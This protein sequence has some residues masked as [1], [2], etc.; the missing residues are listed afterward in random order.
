[1]SLVP[2]WVG[3]EWNMF[4]VKTPLELLRRL[5]EYIME[6]KSY[7]DICDYKPIQ[8]EDENGK[9]SPCCECLVYYPIHIAA[10]HGDI[11]LVKHIELRTKNQNPETGYERNPF[12]LAAFQGHLEICKWYITN[13]PNTHSAIEVN[14]ADYNGWTVLH[15]AASNDQ[16]E[17]F[18]YLLEHGADLY[19]KDQEG[20][21]ALHIAAQLN[22]L[23]ICKLIVEIYNKGGVLVNSSAN[24]RWGDGETPLHTATRYGHTEIVEFILA[25]VVDKNPVNENGDTPLSLAA[26]Y[27]FMEIYRI[28]C[29]HVKDPVPLELGTLRS[30]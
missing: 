16:V 29:Q 9:W 28:I 15:L 19:L 13:I 22:S 2:K 18:N 1:M 21:T 3:K 14:R 8:N 23:K 26:K 5:S 11:D 7:P 12:H 10:L 4:L 30:K 20:Q 24:G 27:E 17:I 6:H 25:N